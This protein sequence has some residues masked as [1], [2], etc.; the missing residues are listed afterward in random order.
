MPPLVVRWRATAAAGNVSVRRH[1]RAGPVRRPAI[2]PRGRRQA[3]NAPRLQPASRSRRV[4]EQCPHGRGGH[5]KPAQA[6]PV[7]A[8]RL[9]KA[10]AALSSARPPLSGL[11]LKGPYNLGFRREPCLGPFCDR[12]GLFCDSVDVGEEPSRRRGTGMPSSELAC[13]LPILGSLVCYYRE[14]TRAAVCHRILVSSLTTTATA[15]R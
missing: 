9:S 3:H 7:R 12:Q 11:V 6:G 2:P 13:M 15:A 5:R 1:R 8:H 14:A 10:V 4:L